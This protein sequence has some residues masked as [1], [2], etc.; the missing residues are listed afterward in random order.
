MWTNVIS[1]T[2]DIPLLFNYFKGC[3]FS[4]GRFWSGCSTR[5]S[6]TGQVDSWRIKKKLSLGRLKNKEKWK[7]QKNQS[8]KKRCFSFCF[9]N[10]G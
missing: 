4:V 3:L 7:F 8:G 2:D 1:L 10:E 5:L 9:T 6:T